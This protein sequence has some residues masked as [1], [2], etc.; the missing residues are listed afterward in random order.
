MWKNNVQKPQSGVYILQDPVF[1][2]STPHV[3]FFPPNIGFLVEK[4]QS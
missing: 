1:L 3:I 4:L 2:Q